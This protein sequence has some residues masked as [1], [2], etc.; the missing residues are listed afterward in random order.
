[1]EIRLFDEALDY[2][3]IPHMADLLRSNFAQ[4]IHD[5]EI[6]RLFDKGVVQSPRF[7]A[8]LAAE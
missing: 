1:M 7:A 6:A 3:R 5:T 4:P 8:P 2:Q